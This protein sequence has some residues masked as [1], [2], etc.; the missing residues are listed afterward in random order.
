VFNCVTVPASSYNIYIAGAFEAACLCLQ[1]FCG[2]K[3]ACFSVTATEYV[4]SGGR[5]SGVIVGII[6]YGRFPSTDES[7]ARLSEEVAKVLILGLHQNS[8]SVVGPKGSMWITRER[9][10]GV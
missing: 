3:G 8:A 4:Y 1:E 10:C 7:L 5:E 6:N 2:E 9:M